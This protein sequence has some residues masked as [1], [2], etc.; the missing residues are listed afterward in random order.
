METPEH[1]AGLVR[2]VKK[3]Y[4]TKKFVVFAPGSITSVI[5]ATCPE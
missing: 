2:K 1:D 3:I 5:P 4:L